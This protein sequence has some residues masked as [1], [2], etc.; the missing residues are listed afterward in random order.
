MSRLLVIY[1]LSSISHK[2]QTTPLTSDEC[3]QLAMVRLSCA[4][5][6]WCS[7]SWQHV[8]KPDICRESWFLP[9]PLAFDTR[10]GGSMSEYCCNIWPGITRMMWLPN[11]EKFWRY[12]Y[13]FWQ[14][15]QT[16][17]HRLCLCIALSGKNETDKW[18]VLLQ[19]SSLRFLSRHFRIIVW[20]HYRNI[21]CVCVTIYLRDTFA[22]QVRS[23]HYQ[24]K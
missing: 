22:M 14:N 4:Y 13:S 10:L 8:M 12:V 3:H 15:I 20:Y 24:S 21:S 1:T 5:N 17:Q 11:S 9:T 16:W 23:I 2:Q 6:I 19:L 7:Q 18:L